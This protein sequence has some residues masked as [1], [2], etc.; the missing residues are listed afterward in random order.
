MHVCALVDLWGAYTH[1][2]ALMCMC[3]CDLCLE[4][5]RTVDLHCI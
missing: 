2:C 3:L 1:I 4:L 5:A